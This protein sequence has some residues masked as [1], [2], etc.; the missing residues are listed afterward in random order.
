[1]PASEDAFLESV[2]IME[3]FTPP[4]DGDNVVLLGTGSYLWCVSVFECVCVCMHVR[5]CACRH[6]VWFVSRESCAA[7]QPAARASPRVTCCAPKVSAVCQSSC[8]SSL[9][10]VLLLT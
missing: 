3:I 4:G 7:W 1:M 9:V 6:A 10:R 2:D 8:G 5:A